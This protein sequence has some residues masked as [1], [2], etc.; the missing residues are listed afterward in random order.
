MSLETF[1]FGDRESP[2]F[3]SLLRPSKQ[4][5]KEAVI[6][7]YP[8]PEEYMR[9]HWPIRG[10][11]QQL[12]Q[13]GFCVFRFDY[14]GTGDSYGDTDLISL[15]K[16]NSNFKLAWEECE[17]IT[18]ADKINVLSI[19]LGCSVVA[20][21]KFLAEQ[22]KLHKIALW[23]CP[24]TGEEYLQSLQKTENLRAYWSRFNFEKQK[25]MYG[26]ELLGYRLNPK[27]LTELKSLKL[28]SLWNEQM[29][30]KH[31]SGYNW[32]EH[33]AIEDSFFQSKVTQEILKYLTGS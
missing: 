9:M 28:N 1:Y 12:L 33:I 18:Q 31:F 5:K 11:A 17:D 20:N 25:N 16:L 26:E 13:I 24:R 32:S 8:G 4:E 3:G 14:F 23:D 7:C 27:F 21:S 19:R 2:L 6:I 30:V 10:F 22:K 29:N 15:E